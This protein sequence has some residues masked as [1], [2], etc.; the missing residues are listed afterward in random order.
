MKFAVTGFVDGVSGSGACASALVLRELLQQGH[1]VHFFSKSSF[2]DPRSLLNDFPKFRFYDVTNHG[3]DYLRQTVKEIPIIRCLGERFDSWTYNRLLVQMISKWHQVNNYDFCLWMG[4]HVKG[5]IPGLPS[6]S[7]YAPIPGCDARSIIRRREEIKRLTSSYQYIKWQF[8][9]FLKIKF[10]IPNILLADHWVT[11]SPYSK[12]T[13]HSLFGVDREKMSNFPLPID[14][15]LFKLPEKVVINPKEP[16]KILWVG[17]IIPRKRLDLFLDAAVIA[18]SRGVN[19][20]L[21]I[22][23]DVKL[24]DGYEKLIQN[25]PLEYRDRLVWLKN[26]IPRKLIPAMYHSHDVFVQPSE[27]E[28]WS[29]P[30][31]AQACGLPVIV[32]PKS[33]NANYLNSRDIVLRE[34]SPENLAMAYIDMWY[35]KRFYHEDSRESRTFAEQ[36]YDVKNIVNSFINQL[37][38]IREE[39][40]ID[41]MKREY[42]IDGRGREV[43]L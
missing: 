19:L 36:N 18:L 28:D 38:F 11:L 7:M 12:E 32:G 29:S 23:G 14:L 9:A 6:I 42:P 43:A 33:G 16:L 3:P 37:F 22:L 24:V 2:V 17:R 35:R 26:G 15:S 25:F 8:L 21:T 39:S 27:E 5:R 41:N 20:K 4:D 13:I 31:E 1:T 10:G 40:K 30:A 34:Y